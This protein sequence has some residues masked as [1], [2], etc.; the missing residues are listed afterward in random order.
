MLQMSMPLILLLMLI[1]FVDVFKFLW[2]AEEWI[3]SQ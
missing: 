1:F 3:I 2:Y